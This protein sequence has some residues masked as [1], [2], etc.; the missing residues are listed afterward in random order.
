MKDIKVVNNMK[1]FSNSQL[2]KYIS[3]NTGVSFITY[4]IMK[5]LKQ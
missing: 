1:K 3:K 5:N 2:E 4:K